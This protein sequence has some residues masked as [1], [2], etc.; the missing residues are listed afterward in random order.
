MI[1][2][3]VYPQEKVKKSWVIGTIMGGLFVISFTAMTI[4][5]LGVNIT[6][7]ILYPGWK[8]G[9]RVQLGDF[10]QKIQIA[11]NMLSFFD[12]Y[13]RM[14]ICFY[15]SHVGLVQL[16]KIKNSRSFILPLGILLVLLAK[17]VATDTSYLFSLDRY[18][19]FLDFFFALVPALL[20]LII[21]KIKQKKEKIS[22]R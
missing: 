3:F 5:V 16:F 20:L 13:C 17:L 11:I 21:G 7:T 19:P 2:P 9:M 6:S 4:L 12:L 22:F 1:V 14:V 18:K 8:L 10:F 15:C